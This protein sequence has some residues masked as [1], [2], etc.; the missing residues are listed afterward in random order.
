MRYFLHRTTLTLLELTYIVA[1]PSFHSPTQSHSNLGAALNFLDFA[2]H[3]AYLEPR[4]PVILQ[5]RD[6]TN[7]ANTPTTEENQRL[8]GIGDPEDDSLYRCAENSTDNKGTFLWEISTFP[9][10][11]LFGTLH[12]AYTYVWPQVAPVVKQTFLQADSVYFELDLTDPDTLLRLGYCQLL[13]EN[14][15][16]SDILSPSLV[17]RLEKYLDDFQQQIDRSIK[18][19]RR[20]YASYIYQTITKNWK[21]RR[22]IWLL[23]LLNS[24]TREEILNRGVPVLDLFMA[25]EARRL[26]KRRGA[27]EQVDDQC[28]PLN[29]IRA[30]QISLALQITLET[31]ERN[32]LRDLGNSSDSKQLQR[33]MGPELMKKG[34]RPKSNR[35]EPYAAEFTNTIDK[36]MHQSAGETKSGFWHRDPVDR[37]VQQYNCGDLGSLV[38]TARANVSQTPSTIF[39]SLTKATRKATKHTQGGRFISDGTK[40]D[41][42]TSPAPTTDGLNRSIQHAQLMLQLEEYLNHELIVKRNIRMAKEIT[43]RLKEAEERRKSVFFALGAA[44]FLGGTGSVIDHLQKAGYKIVR[45]P[46]KL[47]LDNIRSQNLVVESNEFEKPKRR[48]YR[49]D[50]QSVPEDRNEAVDPLAEVDVPEFR[51][52]FV[53]FENLW[54]KI[55]DFTPSVLSNHRHGSGALRYANPTRHDRKS[56]IEPIK[57]AKSP[58]E[59]AEEGREKTKKNTSLKLSFN[60]YLFPLMIFVCLI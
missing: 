27:V 57:P 52:R 19:E 1:I 40:H 24:L 3:P 23:L 35:K 59:I 9:P 33:Q 6:V 11:Y 31:L 20:K 55:E 34:R 56:L 32:I 13:P 17:K 28:N 50:F 8:V 26:G 30:E 47:V 60:V 44:H 16:L 14:E 25:Q 29:N 43:K 4:T 51:P 39:G 53:N 58:D 37:L 38:Q 36:S 22:P 49:N 21:R 7:L 2:L 10:S 12:V 48:G 41:L 18:P 54:I 46:R 42:V 5:K 15:T 45:V